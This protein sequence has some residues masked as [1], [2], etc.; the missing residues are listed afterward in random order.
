MWMGGYYYWWMEPM[1]FHYLIPYLM[2]HVIC[3]IVTEEYIL[4]TQKME[5]F[6][7]LRAK[8]RL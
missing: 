4:D 5:L 8:K 1:W 7:K 3:D 2:S 6:G